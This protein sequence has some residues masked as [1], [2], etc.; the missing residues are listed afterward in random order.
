MARAAVQAVA[1]AA[2]LAALLA[3]VTLGAGCK[4]DPSPTDV[5][6]TPEGSSRAAAST[7]AAAKEPAPNDSGV[8]FG[9][10]ALGVGAKRTEDSK[11]QMSMK[12]TIL[13]KTIDMQEDDSAKK[14]EEVLEVAGDRRAD[15]RGRGRGPCR[16]AFR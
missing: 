2:Y 3:V 10:K 12:L 13:K 5:L 6:P 16:Q 8:K 7:A 9:K 11:M 15:G 14:D 4:K 1:G